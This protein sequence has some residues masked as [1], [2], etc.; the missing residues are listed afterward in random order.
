MSSELE[1]LLREARSSLP[2]SSDEASDRARVRAL[3]AVAVRPPRRRP[4]LLAGLAVVVALVLGVGIGASRAPE[5]T[6]APGG[7]AGFGFLPVNGWYVVQN[8]GLATPERPAIA[9]AA[10]VPIQPGD[11][12]SILPYATLQ[13]LPEDGVVLVASIVAEGASLPLE[14]DPRRAFDLPLR[15][16]A[17]TTIQYGAQVRP[18][19]P[20]G[21]Y[22]IRASVRG[23]SVDVHLYYGAPEPTAETL[24]EAQRQ[25]DRLVLRL[26]PDEAPVATAPAGDLVPSRAAQAVTL[27]T[28]RVFDRAC[29]CYRLRF[30]GRISAPREGEY[31]AVLRQQCG[32]SFGTAV[33]GA[34]TQAGGFWEAETM[35]SAAPGRESAS[36]WARWNDSESTRVQF[37]GRFFVSLVGIGS[38]RFRATVQSAGAPQQMAG[39]TIVLQRRTARGWVRVRSTRLKVDTSI[40]GATFA[41]F[42]YPQ[43]R[44]QLRALVPAASAR[45]CFLA[46]PSETVRS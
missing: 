3:A 32:T 26:D 40:P 12:A 24:L 15:V 8:G 44:H 20:L 42:T 11:G 37:R 33:A 19:R 25:L 43:R 36:Y 21:Q 38:G 1:R 27:R 29:N 5:V 31:V 14:I 16:S 28:V 18:E 45:P 46:S 39:R 6:A 34:Q 4:V 2:E 30:S 23:Y 22:Q 35:F 10:N 9:T 13:L 7:P 17:A 41:I